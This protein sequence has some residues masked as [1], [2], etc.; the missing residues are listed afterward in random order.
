MRKLLKDVKTGSISLDDAAKKLKLGPAEELGFATIDHHRALRL[1]FPEVIYCQGKSPDEV[2]AIIDRIAAREK[3]LLATR[4]G[5]DIYTKVRE[6]HGSAKYYPRA[7]VITIEDK[8]VEK[9]GGLILVVS[10]GTSDM[11]VAEEAMVTADIMGNRVATLYD[12]GVAGIHRILSKTD[13]LSEAS[14]IIAVAGMEG[15][16]PSVVAG[17]VD[18]PVIAVPTSHGYGANFGGITPLLAM[19]NSCAA[20]VVVVNINNGFGAGFAASLINR[21]STK[22]A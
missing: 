4:A 16:L 10:A 5:E 6:K 3:N 2:L 12:V 17:L 22:S 20:G 21:L 8:P 13:K 15:A 7:R 1:G 19:L 9:K 14:V 11:D 18:K